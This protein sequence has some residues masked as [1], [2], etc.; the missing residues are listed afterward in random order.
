MKS[1]LSNSSFRGTEHSTLSP[2][3]S[4]LMYSKGNSSI[5]AEG[6]R[7][8]LAQRHQLLKHIRSA[9]ESIAAQTFRATNNPSNPDKL[10][11]VTRRLKAV[12]QTY[13]TALKINIGKSITHKSPNSSSRWVIRYCRLIILPNAWCKR[14]TSNSPMKINLFCVNLIMVKLISVHWA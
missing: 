5:R 11:K 8:S 9:L 1:A 13:H 4:V 14:T 2:Y 10:R 6:N 3:W 12:L 7:R